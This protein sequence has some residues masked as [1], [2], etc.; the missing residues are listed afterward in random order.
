MLEDARLKVAYKKAQEAANN[1]NSLPEE[2]NSI[3]GFAYSE[4]S[5]SMII[6]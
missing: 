4:I 3:T 1:I 5:F 2:K 6:N